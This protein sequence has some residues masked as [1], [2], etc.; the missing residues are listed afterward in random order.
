MSSEGNW[1]PAT[2]LFTLRATVAHIS[3]NT[4]YIHSSFIPHPGKMKLHET[5]ESWFDSQQG[6][7]MI[8]L[9]KASRS[10]LGSTQPPIQRVFS[11]GEY[12]GQGVKLTTHLHLGPRLRMSGAIHPLPLRLR[13]VQRNN[14]IFFLLYGTW[15]VNIHCTGFWEKSDNGHADVSDK[16]YATIMLLRHVQWKVSKLSRN[17]HV[18]YHFVIYRILRNWSRRRFGENLCNNR[19]FPSRKIKSNKAFK[20][21]R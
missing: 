2:A 4:L 5:E 14:F 15:K 13:G 11:S 18:F 12:S 7:E 21:R 9:T 8:P 16:I 3:F 10:I 19:A 20:K 1:P 6:K 17:V